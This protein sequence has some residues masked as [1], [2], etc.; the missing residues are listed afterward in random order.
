MRL[1]GLRY[2]IG[3]PVVNPRRFQ[4]SMTGVPTIPRG[5]NRKG[6]C[7]ISELTHEF[8]TTRGVVG[9]VSDLVEYDSPLLMVYILDVPSGA[10]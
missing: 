4:V 1:G 9:C 10:T 2:Q 3:I 6:M 7:A 5:G 8:P